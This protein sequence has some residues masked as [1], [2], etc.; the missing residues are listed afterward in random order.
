M[1]RLAHFAAGAAA[2]YHQSG[3]GQGS[4]GNELN[5]REAQHFLTMPSDIFHSSIGGGMPG[6]DT[7]RAGMPVSF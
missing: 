1:G 7:S 3:R 2:H 6:W 5:L 4:G